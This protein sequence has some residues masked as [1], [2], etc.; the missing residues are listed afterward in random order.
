M[1]PLYAKFC[2]FTDIC[3]TYFNKDFICWNEVRHDYNLLNYIRN[4]FHIF[5]LIIWYPQS[6][7][8]MKYT[9]V[10]CSLKI[11]TVTKSSLS[12]IVS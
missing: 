3:M 4:C 2:S 11:L 9:R 5:L 12:F 8:Q 6:N 10:S 7:L 1:C